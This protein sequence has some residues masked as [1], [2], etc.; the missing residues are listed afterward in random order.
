MM[1]NFWLFDF[2][3]HR[4]NEFRANQAIDKIVG[5]GLAW[6]DDQSEEKSY[7]FPSLFP[8]REQAAA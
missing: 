1:F 8:K 4:W 7:W 3:Q 5:E 2:E 6:V